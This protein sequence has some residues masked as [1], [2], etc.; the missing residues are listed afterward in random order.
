MATLASSPLNGVQRLVVKIGSAL[1]VDQETGALHK[2]WLDALIDDV[3]AL[4]A[5]GLE[6]LLVSSGSIALGRKEL[7]ISITS[8]RLEEKQAAAAAGQIL[9]AHAYQTS[10]ARHKITAAQILLSPDD[11]EERR[12][13]LNARATINTLLAKRAIPVINENDTVAT[14]EIRFG[15][16][17]R[18]GARVAQMTSADM[19]VLLSD[20]DGLYSADPRKDE[21][22][23]HIPV[24]ES[25]TDEIEAMAG[26]AGTGYASGGMVTKLAAA[27]IAASAGCAMLI[28]NGRAFNPLRAVEEGGICTFFKAGATPLSARKKW[29]AS[30]L[31]PR[32]KLHLDAG[33]VRALNSGKSLLPAGMTKVEGRFDRGDLVSVLGPDGQVL[34]TGLTAYGA[35]EARQIA[36]LKSREIEETLGYRGRDEMIHRDDLVMT[37]NVES[38]K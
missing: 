21:S 8:A 6:V 28:A 11:T 16:N 1:L 5:Q 13:H 7:D 12:R 17:D 9:L 22:A 30:S 29:I 37:A 18:L 26:E 10:L 35:Q 27:K 23:K 15:D 20:I 2:A 38:G 14:A 24:V 19:L 32:G 36:G 31:R 25:V 34:A 3:A 4:H 33:A